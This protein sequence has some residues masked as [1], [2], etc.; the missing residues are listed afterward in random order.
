[1]HI[2]STHFPPC[3]FIDKSL[4]NAR[5]FLNQTAFY[6]YRPCRL[7]SGV[8]L[9]ENSALGRYLEDYV[10]LVDLTDTGRGNGMFSRFLI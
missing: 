1:M 5:I 2:L 10:W 8:A 4:I 3:L 7:L 6:K 9:L